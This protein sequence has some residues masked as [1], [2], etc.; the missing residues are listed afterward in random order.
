MNVTA[1]SDFS[2]YLPNLATGMKSNQVQGEI[3]VAV[4]KSVLD[5]QKTTGEALVQMIQASS[6]S[7]DLGNAVDLRA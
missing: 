4:L 3:Q 5:N 1:V 2:N 6:I 7:P